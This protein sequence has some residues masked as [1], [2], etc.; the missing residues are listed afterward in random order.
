MAREEQGGDRTGGK[1]ARQRHRGEWK[2]KAAT[3]G[4]PGSG[5]RHQGSLV[6]DC[7]KPWGKAMWGPSSAIQESSQTVIWDE[8]VADARQTGDRLRQGSSVEHTYFSHLLITKAF[9]IFILLEGKSSQKHNG[10][11]AI[12]GI[13]VSYVF[14]SCKTQFRSQYVGERTTDSQKQLIRAKPPS[15][16]HIFL[17]LKKNMKNLYLRKK[18][19][20][21]TLEELEGTYEGS[22]WW[23]ILYNTL[24]M[25]DYWWS[26]P[27]KSC[28]WFYSRNS[29]KNEIQ[30]LNCVMVI[31]LNFFLL[32]HN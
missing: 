15:T 20:P 22:I 12:P 16:A 4:T 29:E 19:N 32:R 3:W 5:L 8:A 6:D 23:S 2:A 7:E 1:W 24:W 30:T 9:S 17:N 14:K 13:S 25:P 10:T 18:S 31:V 21:R 28:W 27:G 26:Q 11:W